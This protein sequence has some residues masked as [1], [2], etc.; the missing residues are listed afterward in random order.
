MH[1]K[2]SVQIVRSE[3]ERG[4]I[5]KSQLRAEQKQQSKFFSS[6][7]ITL[8]LTLA[9]AWNGA[10]RSVCVIS[11]FYISPVKAKLKASAASNRRGQSYQN[12]GVCVIEFGV[13]RL[14]RSI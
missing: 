1:G 8:L 3:S 7:Y 13:Q 6:H 11:R 2:E 9:F 12:L 14:G 5:K 10:W 4:G